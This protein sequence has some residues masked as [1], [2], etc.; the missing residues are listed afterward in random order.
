MSHKNSL[1]MTD[2]IVKTNEREEIDIVKVMNDVTV[3]EQI[4]FY[5]LVFTVFTISISYYYY[6]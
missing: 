6:Y 2:T 3:V 4:H 5:L 1:S